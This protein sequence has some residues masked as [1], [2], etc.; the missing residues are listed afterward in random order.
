MSAEDEVRSIVYKCVA[1]TF[2]F[3]IDQLNDSM[4]AG[5]IGG[6]DSI[7]TS[8]LI[9]NLEESFDVEF[10]VDQLIECEN[11]GSM[12]SLIANIRHG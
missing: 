6:W 10:P 8:Y 5:D 11:L 7:S 4:N 1:D 12:I 3:P 2:T 9:M